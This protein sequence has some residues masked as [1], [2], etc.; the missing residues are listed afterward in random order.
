MAGLG[1]KDFQ[2]GAVLSAADVDGYL[3][4]QSVMKFANTAAAGSAY[5]TAIAEGMNFY[6]S[7]T[8]EVVFH[9]GTSFVKQA[10]GDNLVANG[11]FDFWSRS[12]SAAII[13][14]GSVPTSD[15]WYAYGGTTG[16]TSSRQTT[17]LTGFQYCN[18]I[19][20]DS[21]NTATNAIS[22]R[23]NIETVNSIPF[24]GKTVTLSFYG[25]AGAN[26]SATS[27]GLA[28]QLKSG[29]GTDENSLSY[30][31]SVNVI[32]QTATL[33]TSWQRFTY[34]GTVD[35]NA[36]ELSP[37]FVFIPTGTAGAADYFEIT[38][39]QLELGAVATP[40]NRSGGNRA[41]DVLADG[42]AGFDGVLVATNS[43]SNPS[44][45]GTPAWAG[46]DV[47]G[48]NKIINGGFD[49]WQ[50]GTSVSAPPGTDNYISADRWKSYNGSGSSTATISQQA[51]TPGNAIAGY[52]SPFFFRTALSGFTTGNFDITNRI[53]DV[54]TLA[55]Q[56]ATLSFFAKADASRT[57]N[58]FLEQGY[59][60]GG[61]AS[62]YPLFNQPV[63]VTTSWQR[64]TFVVNMSSISGKTVGA[65]SFLAA[66]LR[67][68]SN[69]TL[70]IWGVQLEA[71]SVATPFSRAG[72]TLQGELAACQRYYYR[73]GGQ[74]A[75]TTFGVGSAASTTVPKFVINHP[76][77][78]RVAPTSM[79]YANLQAFD[80][81][82]GLAALSSLAINAGQTDSHIAWV[83]GA[84]SLLTQYRPY[85]LIATGTNGYV[86]FSAEL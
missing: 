54:R 34:S 25:R 27:S 23:Q 62:T 56:T 65:G 35:A 3:M 26:Y 66:I 10:A 45:S 39:V 20:R 8:D 84:T 1:R 7:D 12:T 2:A 38:G 41:T 86:G 74:V 68:T 40:F 57:V 33:T 60:S 29:T 81:A 80:G 28:V 78:M 6:L 14:T 9:N 77:P 79:D 82:T 52:E 46:Y 36:T 51:F 76:V 75:N 85:F 18:R 53:E 24:A 48:K 22:L 30:T 15:R 64:F 67:L 49:I 59:G 4:D 61:S 50:R 17:G 16:R 47:A 70:D 63:S 83:E 31:G 69:A 11:G 21:G 5:G 55:G 71:G 42:S 13:S 37:V 32:N 43:S 58:V 73:H 19:A 44:G 72:G